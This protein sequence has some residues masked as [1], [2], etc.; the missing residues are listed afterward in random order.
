VDA[1]WTYFRDR[2]VLDEAFAT[3]LAA[4][5]RFRNLTSGS[6]LLL[7]ARELRNA[8]SYTFRLENFHLWFVCDQYDGGGGAIDVGGHAGRSGAAGRDGEPGWAALGEGNS[9]PG[10]PGG[11]GGDGEPGTDAASLTLFCRDLREARLLANGGA[12]G[13]GGPGGDG[14]RG[15][16]G[17]PANF[18]HHDEVEP[19]SGGDG[20][21]GGNGADGGNA[22]R[23]NVV[24]VGGVNP[25]TA[26][27]GGPAG[28]A[29][30]AGEGGR[31][32]RR[33]AGIDVQAGADGAPG[34]A[35]DAG[36]DV[37]AETRQMDESAY[38]EHLRAQLGPQA[39]RWAQYRLRVGEYQF[40]LFAPASGNEN[41]LSRA[42]D[43]FEAALRLDPAYA[44]A[45][46]RW[47]AANTYQN[48]FGLPW[49][50]DL[51]PEFER[52]QDVLSDHRG[53]VT[54]MFNS[55]MALLSEIGDVARNRMRL[56]GE[57]S[58]VG[59]TITVLQT[60]KAA[61]E[62][63][64]Q[65]AKASLDHQTR[66]LAAHDARIAAAEA[67]LRQKQLELDGQVLGTVFKVI[68]AVGA[69][70]PGVGSAIAAVGALPGLI[71]SF[72]RAFPEL[73]R[74]K[75]GEEPDPAGG[76]R[77]I[78]KATY[79]GKHLTDWFE[80]RSLKLKPEAQALVTGLKE[81]VSST[82]VIVDQVKVLAELGRAN[83][84]GVPD[85]P[86]KEL[87][88][89]RV[90]FLFQRAHAELKLRQADLLVDAVDLRIQQATADLA[91]LRRQ[92]SSLSDSAQLLGQVAATLVRRAQ[93][94]ADYLAKYQF[95]AARALD[96]YALM[97]TA[98]AVTFDYGYI[99]PD[100]EENAYLGISRGEPDV[101]NVLGLLRDYLLS[102][103]RLPGLIARDRY[104]TYRA[105][106]T[107]EIRFWHINNEA[108]L[109]QLR[110]NRFLPFSISLGEL[111][112]RS[113]EAKV[114]TVFVSLVG[115]TADD[116]LITCLLEH[117][118]Q[119]NYRR[120]TGAT[121]TVNAPARS[122]PVAASKR[123]DS[124]GGILSDLHTPFWGRSPAT[125][126]RLIIEPEEMTRSNVNLSALTEVQV[127]IAF[128]A[129]VT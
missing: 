127:G 39:A 62:I 92:Q 32:G 1:D 58:H 96:I 77:G 122:A 124:L 8:P 85:S 14:G 23:I 49:D 98:R 60:E 24:Y 53:D 113:F 64:R 72:Q 27:T 52:Y 7:A 19:T 17:I 66:Q 117:S 12:G 29:G 33:V 3:E 57:L 2:I 114:D 15:G 43:E 97:D 107:P 45:A 54:S 89:E 30:A 101:S 36:R 126:W 104:E 20:G 100:T 83:V 87:L 16:A 125:Q 42:K 4:E 91:T 123:A 106:L 116:P 26:S 31:A 112:T 28:A 128:R 34:S 46:N 78:Y 103:N 44:A 51:V 37:A 13:S 81:I 74:V 109:R 6:T 50:L 129:I 110:D 86:Y 88:R 35:A 56:E 65:A 18:P 105:R 75:I 95:L 5:I 115:S 99:E 38:W 90:E 41:R 22:G 69:L 61:A 47:H 79:R 118:G 119:S 102:W 67:E 63:G 9:R 55:A 73:E 71:G 68:T 94:Y 80:W 82:S 84:D 59:S 120:T 93:E 70:I 121:L 25:I 48:I 76:T 21:N 111:P 10:A 108:S 40:R 11:N